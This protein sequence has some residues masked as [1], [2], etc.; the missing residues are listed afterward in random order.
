MV[1]FEV[2]I[3]DEGFVVFGKFNGIGNEGVLGGVVDEGGVFEDVSNSEDGGGRDFFVVVFNGFE[4]V[5]G[6]V[7][8][9]FNEVSEMFSVGGLLDDDMVKVVGSFEVIV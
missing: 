7:V 5:V 3:I 8:D 6:S 9:I 1:R 2:I 4:E